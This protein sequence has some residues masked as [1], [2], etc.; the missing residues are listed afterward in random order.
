DQHRTAALFAHFGYGASMG[1]GY[2]ILGR[3][4]RLPAAVRGILYGLAVYA[5][6][7]H[8]YLPAL[9]ILRPIAQHPPGRRV[10]LIAAHVVW[11]L[12]TA[13]LTVAMGRTD[14]RN[15]RA[16]ALASPR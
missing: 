10:S 7:Y 6:S 3:H 2:G 8:G 5:V 11:G 13:L 1:A 12:A 14:A 9:R 15:A 16:S 4:L